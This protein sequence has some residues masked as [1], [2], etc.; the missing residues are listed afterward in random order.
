[1]SNETT[2]FDYLTID[3]ECPVVFVDID[4]VYN[5]G[6][7]PSDRAINPSL[8]SNTW[9]SMEITEAVSSLLDVYHPQV[10]IISNWVDSY[11]GASEEPIKTLSR[12]IEYD[13]V[14]GSLNS[15]ESDIRASEILRLV[16]EK[17]L[18]HWIVVDAH[19]EYYDSQLFP[20]W[21]LISPKLEKGLGNTEL[22]RLE[23][24]LTNASI[25]P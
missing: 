8:V 9:V 10:V 12:L 17:A 11:L 20:S 1:M 25:Q 18:S 5:Q 22:T 24:F 23:S 15:S 4:G 21:S 14:I 6:T 3:P 2:S 19:A 16:K 7:K 13:G